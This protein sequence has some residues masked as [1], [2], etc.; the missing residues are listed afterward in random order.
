MTEQVQLSVKGMSCDGCAKGIVAALRF[1]PGVKEVEVRFADGT[2]KIE[3][4]AAQVQLAALRDE[5][6]ALEYEVV[7]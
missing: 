3:Y 6:E 1:V 7:D 4:D 2:V 5:I